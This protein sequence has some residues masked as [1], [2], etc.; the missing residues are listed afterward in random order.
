MEAQRPIRHYFWR[1]VVAEVRKIYDFG[2]PQIASVVMFL[3]IY[4]FVF[5]IYY[6]EDLR[7]HWPTPNAYFVVPLLF[8]ATWGKTILIFAFLAAFSVYCVTVESQYGMIRVLCAQPLARW[9][10]VVGKY[11]AISCHVILLTATYVLSL[12]IWAT[13]QAG[14]RGFTFDQGLS[15]FD[16]FSKVLI[17]S[18]GVSWISVSVALLRRTMISALVTT[19]FAFIGLGLLTTYRSLEFG[20]YHFVRYYFIALENLPFP[21]KPNVPMYP[22]NTFCLVTLITCLIFFL[23]PLLYLQFR[24]ITE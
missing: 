22:Y 18:L 14:L 24:D 11:A 19:C 23:P 5:Q 13:V 17:Y 8:Y 15:L 9:Q 4:I 6:V 7:N 10:Y 21:F 2:F 16:F 12:F 1:F 3:A 20:Q